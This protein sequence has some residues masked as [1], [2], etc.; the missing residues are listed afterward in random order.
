MK[1]SNVLFPLKSN[2]IK[3]NQIKS[4]HKKKK[5]NV[6]TEKMEMLTANERNALNSALCQPPPPSSSY[7]EEEQDNLHRWSSEFLEVY[8]DT[9]MLPCIDLLDFALLQDSDNLLQ[10]LLLLPE[11]TNINLFYYVYIRYTHCSSDYLGSYN[12]AAQDEYLIGFNRLVDILIEFGKKDAKVFK[13]LLSWALNGERQKEIYRMRDEHNYFS[14]NLSFTM[15]LVPAY[16][17]AQEA[18]ECYEAFEAYTISPDY[19]NSKERVYP[20]DKDEAVLDYLVYCTTL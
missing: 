7:S 16:F 18:L 15:K 20:Y 9:D 8:L 17:T 12:V 10:V 3:S 14:P 11:F 5:M 1:Y 19:S 4:N 6:H 13:Q 2:Q